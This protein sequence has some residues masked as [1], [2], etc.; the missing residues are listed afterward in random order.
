MIRYGNSR[1]IPELKRL[2]KECFADEDAYIDAFFEAMYEDEYVLMEEENGVL[3][4][5]SFFLPGK[6]WLDQPESGQKPQ[7]GA[8]TRHGQDAD[9]GAWQQIRYV[10]ALAVWPQYRGQGIAAKLLRAAHEIYHAPLLAEPAEESLVGGFYRP[11]G[12]QENFYL[13]KKQAV[14]PVYDVQAAEIHASA[15]MPALSEMPASAEM[16]ASSDTALLPVQAAAYSSIRDKILKAHGY[17]S[18]PVRHV[19][20]AIKEHISSGGGAFILT[21]GGRKDLLLYYQEGQKAVVT[22]TT[23]SQEE[24][25]K[26]L[27]PR[28]A[29]HCTQAVFTSAAKRTDRPEKSG[30]AADSKCC[31]TG[32][33]LGLPSMYGYLNL[34]LDG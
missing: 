22:E 3:L 28:I 1:S 18:W 30:Y 34:S 6:I 13:M 11:L 2:W 16:P 12:F 23:L 32:M 26:W 33:S 8:K 7:T 27:F 14:L 9:S 25:E 5:A 29:G 4:G 17:I 15:Q 19:A 20:F 10:Y 21:R 31:L 24:A